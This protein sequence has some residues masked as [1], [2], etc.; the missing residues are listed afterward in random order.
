MI[1]TEDTSTA[2][3]EEWKPVQSS[4]AVLGEII[5]VPSDM[6]W[7]KVRLYRMGSWLPFETAL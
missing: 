3:A 7:A 2:L 5:M 1:A 6:M 4:L